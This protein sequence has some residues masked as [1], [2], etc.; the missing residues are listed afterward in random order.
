MF[1][2]TGV[3]HFQNHPLNAGEPLP[4]GQP[5]PIRSPH[6]SA[7]TS[8]NSPLLTRKTTDYKQ[9]PLP[10][11]KVVPP[12]YSL[13][14]F[15]PEELKGRPNITYYFI[16]STAVPSPAPWTSPRPPPSTLQQLAADGRE[17][18]LTQLR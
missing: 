2:P 4:V 18:L 3:H 1:P 16:T 17:Q 10:L 8:R 5:S 9:S 14:P 15:L 6:P 11:A 13:L 7:V 12:R